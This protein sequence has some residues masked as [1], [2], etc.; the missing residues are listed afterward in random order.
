MNK[1]RVDI[2]EF[3]GMYYRRVQIVQTSLNDIEF[4]K[5]GEK[6]EVDQKMIDEFQTTG[7]SNVDFIMYC[8]AG[9]GEG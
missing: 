7:L 3:I 9:V 2:E 6:M 1:L 4:Y 8:L 5:D